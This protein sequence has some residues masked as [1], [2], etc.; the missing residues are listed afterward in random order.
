MA[1]V[2]GGGCGFWWNRGGC[3]V[4]RVVRF[5]EGDFFE[6]YFGVDWVGKWDF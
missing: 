4:D 2:L 3:G 5:C 6:L 1:C